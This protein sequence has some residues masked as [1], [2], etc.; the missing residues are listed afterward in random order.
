MRAAAVL[1]V[2]TLGAGQPALAAAATASED[3]RAQILAVVA[4]MQDAWNRGD[5]DGYMQGFWN[6]GVEFVSGGRIITGWQ[7]VLDHYKRDYATPQ[8]RGR[9]A[10]CDLDIQVLA[11]DAAQ[12]VG[13][14]DLER[15]DHPQHGVNTRLFRRIGGRWVIV[16]NH[17]SSREGPGEP[18]C[19]ASA[20]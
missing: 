10:F 15:P 2:L 13:H 16:L 4:N 14:Y 3:A 6:P 12:L 1:L 5:F 8:Q 9:L 18:Y 17:V 7:A 11:P 19:P 20:H